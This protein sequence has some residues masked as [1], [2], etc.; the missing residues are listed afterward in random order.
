MPSWRTRVGCRYKDF[1]EGT[2]DPFAIS[3]YDEITDVCLNLK[4]LTESP[5]SLNT[6]EHDI[7]KRLD[8][9]KR[10]AG[11]HRA[12]AH[13]YPSSSSLSSLIPK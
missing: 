8:R 7:E 9:S 5:F 11:A 10:E 1:I 2:K 3:S 13:P 6:K 12:A 4:G